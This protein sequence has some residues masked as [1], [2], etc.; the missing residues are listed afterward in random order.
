MYLF[1]VLIIKEFPYSVPVKQRKPP[2]YFQ[3][4]SRTYEKNSRTFQD[5]KKNPGLF[6][7]VATLYA[8]RHGSES[9]TRK[10]VNQVKN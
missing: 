1:F 6:Q 8:I 2:R 9:S 10:G 3:G 4:F 7:D 5:S